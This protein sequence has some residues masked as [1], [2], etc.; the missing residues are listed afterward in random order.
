MTTKVGGHAPKP[1][2]P[3]SKPIKKAPPK[4]KK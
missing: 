2:K 3:A 4:T 1:K